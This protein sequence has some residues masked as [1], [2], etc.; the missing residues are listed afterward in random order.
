MN[1]F[2]VLIGLVAL[3]TVAPFTGGASLGLNAIQWGS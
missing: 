3:A 2:Q 1:T